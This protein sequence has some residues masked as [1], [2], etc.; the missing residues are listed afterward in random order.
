V[1]FEI[2]ADVLVVQADVDVDVDVDVDM[3]V[4]DEVG[5]AD[6]DSLYLFVNG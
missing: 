3:N 4:G 2:V 5:V 6:Q 1:D